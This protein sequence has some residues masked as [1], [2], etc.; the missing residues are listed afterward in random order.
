[1][2]QHVIKETFALREVPKEVYYIGLGG[3]VP[4]AGVSALTLYLAWDI[5]YAH[6]HGI[7]YLVS[8]ETAEQVLLFVEP[9]QVGL[10]A[11]ILSFLGAVHWGLEMAEYGGKHGYQRYAL[12]ILAPVLAWPTVR[13][14]FFVSL[15][16]GW[17]GLIGH[18]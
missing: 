13:S 1:M 8:A 10:G 15:F 17:C 5:N 3:T 9:L 16:E 18:R 7:G 12:S 6:H 4:Y 2:V 11:V 14:S